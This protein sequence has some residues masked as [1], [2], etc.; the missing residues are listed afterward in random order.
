MAGKKPT[1]F[2]APEVCPVCGED[3]SRGSLACPNCGADHNSGWKE[4]ADAYDGVDLP[5]EDFNHDEFIHEEFGSSPKP[6]GVNAV[7]WIT[8]ILLIVVFAAVYFF[9]PL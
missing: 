4:N 8:G 5:G 7:W 3:V 6:A 9:R 1:Q 2:E